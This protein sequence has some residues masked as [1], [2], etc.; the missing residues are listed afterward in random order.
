MSWAV[1]E[2]DVVDRERIASSTIDDLLINARKPADKRRILTRAE[3]RIAIAQE[4]SVVVV[5][6]ENLALG[7]GLTDADRERLIQAA[8]RIEYIVGAG[9]PQHH[10]DRS[11]PC[12]GANR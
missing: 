12:I 7:V 9:L 5:A 8:R 2:V 11:L 3:V 4:V 6:A 10:G 1:D